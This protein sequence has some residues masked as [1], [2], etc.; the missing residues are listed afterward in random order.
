MNEHIDELRSRVARARHLLE[1][2]EQELDDALH[3]LQH[4]EID[5]LEDH[6]A[7]TEHKFD[8]LQSGLHEAWHELGEQVGHLRHNL[9]HWFN[10]KLDS[11]D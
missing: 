5:H 8:D 6:L 1:H 9:R 11:N 2:F 3:Q 10:D 7:S 4:E